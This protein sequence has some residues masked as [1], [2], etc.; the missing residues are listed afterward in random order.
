MSSRP[1]LPS[2]SW[3][4][5]F[6]WAAVCFSAILTWALPGFSQT[7]E[8]RQQKLAALRASGLY[9][10][11]VERVPAGSNR[12]CV[13]TQDGTNPCPAGLR[14]VHFNVTY[15]DGSPPFSTYRCENQYCPPSFISIMLDGNSDTPSSEMIASLRDGDDGEINMELQCPAV[16]LWDPHSPNFGSTGH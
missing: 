7:R 1:S 4:I 9:K 8:T 5:R 14:C 6:A 10:T 2:L 12:V 15:R 3:P 13:P 16:N 11:G